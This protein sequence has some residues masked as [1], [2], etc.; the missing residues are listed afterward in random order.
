MVASIGSPTQ[1]QFAEVARTYHE[2]AHLVGSVHQDLGALAGLHILV[3][4]IVRLAI[5]AE[6]AE[7]QFAGFADADFANC[8]AEALHQV[9]RIG[10]GAVGRSESRHRDADYAAAVLSQSVKGMHTNEQGQRGIQATADTQHHRFGVGMLNAFGQSLALHADNLF[11][12]LV[13][14]I[15]SRHEGQWVNRALKCELLLLHHIYFDGAIVVGRMIVGTAMG[16]GR[17]DATVEANGVKVNVGCDE[18]RLHSEP[19]TLCQEPTFLDH[20]RMTIKDEVLRALAVATRTIHIGTKAARTLS[21]YEIIQIAGLTD[22]LVARAEIEDDL[23]TSQRVVRTGRNGC[24]EVF[25]NLYGKGVTLC[26]EEQARTEGDTLTANEHFGIG[27]QGVGRGKPA[28]L[29]KLLVV[30][31]I[32]LGHDTAE[33]ALMNHGR[34]IIQTAAIGNRQTNDGNQAGQAAAKFHHAQ[35]GGFGLVNEQ[36]MGKEV[37]T[38]ISR[39][40]KFGETSHLHSRT[41][42]TGHEGNNLFSIITKI[43]HTYRGNKGSNAQVSVHRVGILFG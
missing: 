28:L 29:V 9:E 33:A 6:V 36:F 15:A 43:C 27:W 7:M 14:G 35:Q 4:H 39:Q 31:Q 2:T 22:K 23:S 20:Q 18:L 30:G 37:L 42:R 26:V 34:T 17:I 24:P 11:A 19:L 32:C 1:S 16:I 41:I 13:E 25:A 3:S 12:T 40:T 8:N 10:V 5:V 38:G 21:C